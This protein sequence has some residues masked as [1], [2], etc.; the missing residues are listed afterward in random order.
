MKSKTT[1]TSAGCDFVGEGINGPND[2][3]RICMDGVNGGDLKVLCEDWLSIYSQP[4]YGADADGDNHVTFADF[5][6]LAERW[7]S[8]L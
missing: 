7:L 2:I 3:W 8:G 1:F 4:F 6:I 5:A